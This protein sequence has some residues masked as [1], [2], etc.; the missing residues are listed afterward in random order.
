MDVAL[1]A[2]GTFSSQ[3]RL[4]NAVLGLRH[5][6]PTRRRAPQRAGQAFAGELS[7]YLQ[8]GVAPRELAALELGVLSTDYLVWEVR[9][10]LDDAFL[11]EAYAWGEGGITIQRWFD[12]GQAMERER[13]Q[14]SRGGLSL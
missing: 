12:L 9:S 14:R 8:T 3:I 13:R 4:V 2:A 5:Y 6:T 10:P 1:V 11:A 7:A